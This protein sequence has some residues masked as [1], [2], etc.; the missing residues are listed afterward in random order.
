MDS[1]AASS[2]PNRVED[3]KPPHLRYQPKLFPGSSHTWAAENLVR[4]EREGLLAKTSKILDVGA[5]SGV[6]GRILKDAGFT[7]SRAIE[8][9]QASAVEIRP[10]YREVHRD[11]TELASDNFDLIFL[12]DV[13]EHAADPLVFL[14]ALTARMNPDGRIFLSVPNVAHWSI[15][16]M[17]LFGFF[18]YAERGI[19]DKT[20]LQFFTRSRIKKICGQAGLAVESAAGSIVPLELVLPK[21]LYRNPIFKLLSVCRITAARALPGLFAFQHL[22]LL[23]KAK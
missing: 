11:I 5:G 23:K 3:S 17:L 15:R 20:H 19:L 7:E 2:S 4:L 18:N 16:L 8:I 22:L 10:L 21:P 12:L 9:D 13:L 14:S 6:I 1:Q